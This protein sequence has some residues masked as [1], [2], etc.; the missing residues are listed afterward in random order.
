MNGWD[1]IHAVALFKRLYDRYE[2][3]PTAVAC[4]LLVI[5]ARAATHHNVPLQKMLDAVKQGARIG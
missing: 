4:D 5:V 1:L 2:S 3:E